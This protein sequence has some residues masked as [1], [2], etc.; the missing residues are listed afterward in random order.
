MK[1]Y[2]MLIMFI[3]ISTYLHSQD[4]N[5]WN[6]YFESAIKFYESKEYVAA[7]KQF[8]KSQQSLFT[9]ILSLELKILSY[10]LSTS[11]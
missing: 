5:H 9:N 2:F 4:G 10:S 8:K 11:T 1:R 6:T 7:E 3:C